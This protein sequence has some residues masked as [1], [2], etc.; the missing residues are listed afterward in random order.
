M[1]TDWTRAYAMAEA[2]SIPLVLEDF[3]WEVLY[4]VRSFYEAHGMMPLTRRIIKFIRETRDP[5]FDSLQ[6][7]ARY[8]AQ[9]L[10]C[11][12]RMAGLP[13]PMQCI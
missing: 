12:A 11:I 9:P 1:M 13:K 6:F 5:H 2:A 10:F 4:F 3:D 8:T 7:Q